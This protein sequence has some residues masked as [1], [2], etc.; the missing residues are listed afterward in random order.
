MKLSLIAASFLSLSSL[1]SASFSQ[2]LNRP[3]VEDAA[4]Y[5]RTLVKR[6]SLTNVNT[7]YNETGFPVSFVEY[8][9]DC[10]NDGSPVLLI[11]DMS[12]SYQNIQKGSP[13]SLSIRVGDHP[14]NEQVDPKYPGSRPNS[15]AGS[16]R[17]NLRGH[18]ET[19]SQEEDPLEYLKLEKCFLKR[20]KDAAWWLPH[21]PIHSSHFAKFV[22]ESIY[23]IG[24]FGDTGYIGDI[25]VEMYKKAKIIDSDEGEEEPPVGEIGHPFGSLGEF[26]ERVDFDKAV[27]EKLLLSL[28]NGKESDIEISEKD[29]KRISP[30]L[31]ESGIQL[32]ELTANYKAVEG[33]VERLNE[34]Q[35]QAM[36]YGY[37]LALDDHLALF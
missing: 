12:S 20:H 2:P 13:V 30:W 26:F 36:E 10:G 15:V 24:G 14:P 9:A 4:S 32:N 8:Y 31:K 19:V 33:V 27:F 11:I 6:E 5:A 23:F 17:I 1:G 37:D 34:L 7:I 18:L 3:T 22:I 21:N 35:R 16:P 28:S 29:L 25:P